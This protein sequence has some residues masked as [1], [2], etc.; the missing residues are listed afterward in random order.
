MSETIQRFWNQRMRSTDNKE[1]IVTLKDITKAY[2]RWT[3]T[4]I[5]VK[6]AKAQDL[7]GYFDAHCAPKTD[8]DEYCFL[9]VFMDEEDVEAY[10]K[11]QLKEGN[12]RIKDLIIK[13]LEYQRNDLRNIL[14]QRGKEI[15]EMREDLTQSTRELIRLHQE[16]SALKVLLSPFFTD[17]KLEQCLTMA[18]KLTLLQSNTSLPQTPNQTNQ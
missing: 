7:K 5:N 13:D 17:E 15:D 9:K 3:L 6:R 16:N 10:D 4:Q 8:R 11:Q 1:D 14:H 18:K 12:E 2:N